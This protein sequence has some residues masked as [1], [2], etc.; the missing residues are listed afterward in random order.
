[1]TLT[2]FQFFLKLLEIT[3][4][5]QRL[6]PTANI[7]T[8]DPDVRQILI[9]TLAF[10]NTSSECKWMIETLKPRSAAIDVGIRNTADIGSYAYGSALIHKHEIQ[11]Q[12][13][14][15]SAGFI[16]ALYNFGKLL[17]LRRSYLFLS[18]SV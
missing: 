7:M 5:L 11:Y 8:S 9:E 1:M 14:K 2:T 15:I 4:F 13:Y 12:L 18:L 10:E 17:S 16:G 3:D 6:I